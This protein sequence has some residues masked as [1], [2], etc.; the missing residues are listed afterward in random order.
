VYESVPFR[1]VQMRQIGLCGFWSHSNFC[2]TLYLYNG[3]HISSLT[4]CIV[5]YFSSAFFIV[6]VGTSRGRLAR[7][8]LRRA[9][10]A[11]HT[12]TFDVPPL[13]CS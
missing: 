10:P 13:L 6:S 12:R 1:Y 3:D 5:P 4:S 11:G 8:I 2:L 9:V 7:L